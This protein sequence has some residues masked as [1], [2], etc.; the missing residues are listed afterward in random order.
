MV[1]SCE[2]NKMLWNIYVIESDFYLFHEMY[3]CK[4][5]F[6]TKT[7]VQSCATYN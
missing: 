3:A 6:D 7:C 2:I 4:Y 5:L 1:S